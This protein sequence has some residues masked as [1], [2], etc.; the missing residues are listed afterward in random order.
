MLKLFPARP[1]LAAVAA[2]AALVAAL[3]SVGPASAAVRPGDVR[4]ASASAFSDWPMFRGDAGRTGSSPETAISTTTAS[5]L[6]STWTKTLGSKSYTSPAV[7]TSATLGEALLYTDA[8]N[9][10]YAF[11]ATAT[12]GKAVWIYKYSGGTVEDSPDVFNG[13][14]YFGTTNG[15]LYALD[16]ST[17]A[18]LCSYSAVDPILSSPVVASDPDGSGPV[19]YFGTTN[20]NAGYGSEWAIYGPGNTH[21]SCTEDWNFTGFVTPGGSWSPPAYG[22][23]A[24]G[25]PLVVFGS[26]DLDDSVY[27]LDA[28]TG[29]LVWDYKTSNVQLQDVGAPPAI[30]GPGEN[31]FADG[32]V[33]VEGKDEVVYALDLTTGSLI[34]SYTLQAGS[35]ASTGDLS[36]ASLVNKAI[37]V[38]SD[39]GL[40]AINAVTG[41][42]IWH[43]LPKSTFYGS[44][45][46]TGP[47]GGRV[48]VAADIEGHIFVLN[49]ANGHELWVKKPTTTGGYY[50]SP[51]ISQ[52]SFFITGFN[53]VLRVYTPTS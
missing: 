34:W 5:S 15:T 24:N 52:G 12:G 44:P 37:Y 35:N 30:S 25:E 22:T 32:V 50:S 33:Y 47:A 31:G 40:Y 26:K 7:A 9:Q 14:V 16:A 42:L 21:G 36:G 46:I 17:G 53:G 11:P 2:G 20:G 39:D 29:A 1:V 28:S 8:N 38:G 23:D 43:V 27:A 10:F 4:G 6:T 41:K 3:A 19:A 48:L 45:S 18:L 13:V 51:A 49:L